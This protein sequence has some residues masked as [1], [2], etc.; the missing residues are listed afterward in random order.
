MPV[1]A[2]HQFYIHR[3]HQPEAARRP[4]YRTPL[5][6]IYC[7]GLRLSECLGPTI[8]DIAGQENKLLIRNSKGHQDRVVPPAA[9]RSTEKLRQFMVSICN[10]AWC[11]T[12]ADNEDRARARQPHQ[13]TEHPIAR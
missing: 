7:C 1:Y 5:K 13:Q 2:K 3:Q 12:L 6:L 11:V 10:A 4:Q 9:I 8:H